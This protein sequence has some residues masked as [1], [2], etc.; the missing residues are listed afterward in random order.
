MHVNRGSLP[1][2]FKVIVL[3]PRTPTLIDGELSIPVISL[4]L[5]YSARQDLP[6]LFFSISHDGVR[7]SFCISQ[8]KKNL[9]LLSPGIGPSLIEH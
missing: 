2:A 4:L 7:K 1:R 5:T 3:Y 8:L 9:Q 6:A